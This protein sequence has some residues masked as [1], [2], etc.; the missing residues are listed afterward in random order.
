MKGIATGDGLSNISALLSKGKWPALGMM[1]AAR[2]N[3][4]GHNKGHQTAVLLTSEETGNG[5]Q[6]LVLSGHT[7]GTG[8]A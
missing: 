7:K 1:K 8:P 6:V 4:L 5:L 2:F 3:L